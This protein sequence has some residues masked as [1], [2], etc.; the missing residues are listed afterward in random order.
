MIRDRLISMAEEE[1]RRFSSSLIPD[2]GHMLGVRLPKLRALAREIARGDWRAYLNNPNLEYFEEIMLA[3]MVIGYVKTDLSE[4]LTYTE[5]FIP[6]IDNWSVCDS[7]CCGLKITKKYPSEMF[8]FILRYIES[9][10]EF[11]ARFAVVMLLDY[12]VNDEYIKRVFD[13]LDR[14]KL[15]GYYVKTAVAWLLS[16]C[17]IDFPDLTTEYLNNNISDDFTYNKT[18]SKIIESRRI[19]AGERDRIRRMKRK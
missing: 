12:Y 3:G 16:V 13:C 9:D 19:S 10:K 11:E 2:C 15:D 14:V 6:H 5:S 18:L 4:V 8:S 1:Y 7:F 17:Y